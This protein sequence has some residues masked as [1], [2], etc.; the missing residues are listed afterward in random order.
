MCRTATHR[1]AVRRRRFRHDDPVAVDLFSGYGGLTQGIKMAGFTT[2]MAANHNEYK[3]AVHEANHPEAEH[4]IANLVDPESSDYHSARDLPAGDLLVAGVTCFAAGALVLTRRGLIPIENVVIGDEV[5]THRSRWRPVVDFSAVERPTITVNATTA[6]TCTPDHPFWAAA[7]EAERQSR[8]KYQPLEG[9]RCLECGGPAPQFRKT[10]TARLFC[11]RK[12]SQDNSNRRALPV[13]GAACEVRADSLAGMYVGTPILEHDGREMPAI[14]GVGPVDA[15]I[16]WVLGRW[17][18]DGW[19]SRRPERKDV[20]SRVTI[21]GSH[22]EG[23]DLA[24]K[25]ELLT[26]LPWNRTRRRTTDTFHVDRVGV[27]A[28]LAEN[29][30]HGAAGKRIPEWMLFAPIEIRQS[31][32]DGYISADGHE[33]RDGLRVQSASVSKELA[34]GMRMLLT[35]LGWYATVHYGV[36]SETS[37]IEGRTVRQRPQ[38]T[39]TAHKCR[40]RRTKYRDADGYRWGKASGA[41]TDG[42]TVTVY[43]MTVAEDHTYTVDGI[44]V[45]NCTNHSQANTKK[46]YVQGLSLFDLEDPEFENRAT[47]SE[48]DRATANCVLAYAD[49]HRPRL[50]LVECTTE[51]VSWGPAIP[52]KTKIGDGSTYRWW[53]KQFENM[54]YK[55]RELRLNSMFFGVPQSRDRLYIV[56]WQSHL[57]TPDLDHCPLSWCAGC[58]DVV[59]AVWSWK[60][61]VPDSGTVRYG[62]QYNYR[63]PRCR[64]EVVPPM[65]PSLHALDFTNLGTRIGDR[66]KPLRP[67]TMERIAR[68]RARFEQFP[69]V[70][71]PA[72]G[73]HGSERHPWQPLMTQTSQ[74]E[75]AL[76]STGWILAAHRHNGDGKHFTLPMDTVTSTE[77]KS[78]L[79]AAIN[80]YQ[81]VPRGVD[82]PLPTQAASET[83]GLLT[84]GVVP[85]RRH[86]IPAGHSEPMPTMTSDQIPG[87]LTAAAE[88]REGGQ[89]TMA[90]QWA[91]A[92]AELPVEECRFRMLGPHEVGRGC[93]FDTTFPGHKGSYIVWGTARQQCDG[94]GNAVSPAV[95][96]WLGARLR[97]VLHPS[98]AVA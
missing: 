14:D 12:C 92:L 89:A 52:G 76:L 72:K 44:V 74:Q 61:G 31:F 51:L 45:H 20:W 27:A 22:D 2:I 46:A 96:A 23:H 97:A 39:L 7:G 15:D 59:E 78:V 62:T 33:S 66:Q 3:V 86:T 35:S 71:M 5:W 87:L 24:E 49:Q 21:C 30:G 36:K 43:N 93:G 25:L 90:A 81:G 57:P 56:F 67:S 83:L 98:E 80:N 18:G 84:G 28:F 11:S 55:Y 1:P 13:L 85:F 6:I 29:F 10:K 47:R 54:G 73:T 48:R 70:I 79:F 32:V 69:A 75:T 42:E 4:W 41:V 60:T 64:R 37:V 88:I 9:A 65:T 91:A 94:Y 77:E 53:L 17:L 34:V 63:C 38:W 8:R 50:I 95:G 58:D 26:D 68:C 82:E 16:A 40:D 19:V